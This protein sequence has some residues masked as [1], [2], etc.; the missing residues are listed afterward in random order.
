M[1]PPLVFEWTGDS[2]VPVGG[3]KKVADQHF[4][5]GERYRLAEEH[6]RSQASHNHEFAEI[7]EAWKNLPEH[8]A[9]EFPSPEHLR[10]RALIEA[11]YYS[12][13]ITDCGS[14]AAAERVA[15][16]MR[17]RPGEQFTLVI[18]RGP[19][20]VA[21]TPE[22][23]SRRA[24]GAKRFQESKD[25]VLRVVSELIGVEPGQLRRAEAA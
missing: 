1:I 12:E 19:V 10:K 8:L 2:M 14:K 5:I 11:G 18:T 21:R 9:T 24:M 7:G 22:S 3:F 6:D 13:Q 15:A 17:S 16:M 20:V 23:Q 4:T 25:A